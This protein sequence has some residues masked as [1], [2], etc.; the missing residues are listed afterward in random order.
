ML[1]N[2]I[3]KFSDSENETGIWVTTQLVEASLDIDFDVLYTEMSTADS[4]L[5][6]MGR[7]NR[8]GRHIPDK[9]N[10]H[11]YINANGVGVS[12]AIYNREIYTRSVECLEKYI[13][14]VMT[15]S[16]KS[17]YINKVYCTDEIKDTDY[18]RDIEKFLAMFKELTPAE[19]SKSEADENSGILT[20]LK[21]FLMTYMKIIVKL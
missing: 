15:E 6:R 13:G 3:I 21:L 4:L 1:E 19:Y 11:I 5:Q 9:A 14:R 8:K 17:E 16:D 7:C 10:I 20:V 18:Y 12:R 2:E